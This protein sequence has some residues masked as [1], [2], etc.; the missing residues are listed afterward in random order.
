[1]PKKGAVT[2]F[3]ILG[4]L[5]IMV[6]GLLIALSG[7]S[8][9]VQDDDYSGYN[10]ND[11]KSYIE[12]CL[13]QTTVKGLE[14]LGKQGGVIYKSQ[15]TGNPIT[16][17]PDPQNNRNTYD[18][19]GYKVW[20]G[21]LAGDGFP[22]QKTCRPYW[23]IQ[24]PEF[25]PSAGFPFWDTESPR[26]SFLQAQKGPA[27]GLIE[28]LRLFGER[29]YFD[30]YPHNDRFY[31]ITATSG[32]LSQNKLNNVYNFLKEYI[33]T[34]IT[35]CLDFSQ[36]E[37]ARIEVIPQ[38]ELIVDPVIADDYVEVSLNYPIEITR[39]EKPLMHFEQFNIQT[40]IRFKKIFKFFKD[41]IDQEALNLSF[42]IGDHNL[43][44]S[45]G[46]SS[47][48]YNETFER[49]HFILEITDTESLIP[50][51]TGF[52]PYVFRSAIE[53]SQPAIS[54]IHSHNL[55][56]VPGLLDGI[57]SCPFLDEN[58]YE[59]FSSMHIGIG[60]TI[61]QDE[62]ECIW[63]VYERL[64]SGTG[65]R[66][67]FDPDEDYVDWKFKVSRCDWDTGCKSLRDD[68]TKENYIVIFAEDYQYNDTLNFT[69]TLFNHGPEIIEAFD[70]IPIIRDEAPALAAALDLIPLMPGIWIVG[71]RD[72]DIRF[73]DEVDYLALNV[74]Y[75]TGATVKEI[76]IEN[77]YVKI[78]MIATPMPVDSID[79]LE[80][81]EN[82]TYWTVTFS[83][84]T[85]ADAEFTVVDSYGNETSI[86]ERIS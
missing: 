54:F 24:E 70:I 28:A 6:T 26:V 77:G 40:K 53:N 71:A 68:Y 76:E 12:K 46:I 74:N 72:Q 47:W 60:N 30:L 66:T 80:E 52:E 13:F 17:I 86:S 20:K 78:P 65:Y 36:F 5:I 59:D 55:N 61:G 16:L 4:I 67:I 14:L 73:G 64:L 51:A 44:A 29:H 34:N 22:T 50:T 41:I 75:P 37:S 56:I 18:Y 3:I 11:V 84:P 19:D 27:P 43:P 7:N 81:N 39:D 42:D 38:G 1:M 10:A 82:L 45:A 57:R 8:H 48:L 49:N 32:F 31:Q 69:F 25:C 58:P 21:I 35:G 62:I 2:I 9:E 33:E 83:L 79:G 63:Y 15:G 85:G 23:P